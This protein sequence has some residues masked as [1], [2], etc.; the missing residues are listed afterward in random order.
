MKLCHRSDNLLC[1]II[2]SKAASYAAIPDIGCDYTVWPSSLTWQERISFDRHMAMLDNFFLV[3]HTLARVLPQMVRE[4]LHS[5]HVDMIKSCTRMWWRFSRP[6][7]QLALQRLVEGCSADREMLAAFTTKIFGQRR[8][9]K[10]LLQKLHGRR[11][12]FLHLWML[13]ERIRC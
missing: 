8:T 6:Q 9:L 5:N 12:L 1:S 4:V 3:W 11:S 13:L 2:L 10:G 7:R